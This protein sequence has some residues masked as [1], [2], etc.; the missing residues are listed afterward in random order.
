MKNKPIIAAVIVSIVILTTC[1]FLLRV[2]RSMDI[3]TVTAKT[4]ISEP[5]VQ[6][7]SRSEQRDRSVFSEMEEQEP[8]VFKSGDKPADTRLIQKITVNIIDSEPNPENDTGYT[9]ETEFKA[10]FKDSIVNENTVRAFK[11]LQSRFSS[12]LDLEKHY[13]DVYE[14]LKT[15]VSAEKAAEAVELYKKFTEY[16]MTLTDQAH[17]WNQEKPMNSTE[18]IQ[19]LESV[20]RH[21]EQFFGNDV[22]ETLW[23]DELTAYEYQLRK[24]AVVSDEYMN[25]DEKAA[26]IKDLEKELFG[27]DP[28][29]SSS[30]YS[31]YQETLQLYRR[32]FERMTPQEQYDKAKEIRHEIFPPD[33]A[34]RMD[35]REKARLA[36]DGIIVLDQ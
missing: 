6:R 24:H 30:P 2:D 3:E 32:D 14:Y 22:A 25:G 7:Q 10:Y 15:Q 28:D 4:E 18:A 34:A 35:E 29:V 1:W 20:Q 5:A 33:A 8:D 9:A 31:R 19:F 21:R 13:E 27:G 16:E 36:D 23:G 17:L 26:R 11:I 12:S